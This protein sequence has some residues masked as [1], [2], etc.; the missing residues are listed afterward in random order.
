MRIVFKFFRHIFIQFIF[1]LTDIFTRGKTNTIA[2][3]KNM[4]I[5]RNRWLSKSGI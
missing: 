5:H 1:D 2:H 4:C 3:S